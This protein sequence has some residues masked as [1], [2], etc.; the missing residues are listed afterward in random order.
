VDSRRFG[1]EKKSWQ[2]LRLRRK[3]SKIDVKVDAIAAIAAKAKLKT[4]VRSLLASKPLAQSCKRRGQAKYDV[5]RA[6][7]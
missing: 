6:A 1:F 2:R 7:V 5:V 3:R 4:G